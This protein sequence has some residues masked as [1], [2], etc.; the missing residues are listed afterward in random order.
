MHLKEKPTTSKVAM[1]SEPLQNTL[2]G[3]NIAWKKESQWLTNMVDKLTFI[4]ATQ[5]STINLTAE[6]AQLIAGEVKGVQ[7]NASYLDD[8]E[9]TEN[10]IDIRQPESWM[11]ASTPSALP[12]AALSN[13]VRYGMDRALLSWY[14]IDPLFTRRSSSLTPGHIKSDLE[15]LSNHYVREVYERELYPNKEAEW[16]KQTS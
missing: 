15:Q 5:P 2:W 9:N 14:Y 13:D 11:I 7:G 6:F 3:A 12:N 4:E 1:G 10:G 16:N 8:F